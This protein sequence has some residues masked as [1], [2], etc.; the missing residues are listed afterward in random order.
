MESLM[1]VDEEWAWNGE[2]QGES[3]V[4]VRMENRKAIDMK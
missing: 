2:G 3:R 4:K 1:R